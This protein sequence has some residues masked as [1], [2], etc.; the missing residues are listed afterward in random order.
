MK[1][2][3]S[4]PR[5]QKQTDEESDFLCSLTLNCMFSKEILDFYFQHEKQFKMKDNQVLIIVVFR[6][7]QIKDLITITRS[8]TT[9]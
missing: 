3:A 1:P 4:V 9:Y 6:T 7:Y 5:V 8:A 2:S